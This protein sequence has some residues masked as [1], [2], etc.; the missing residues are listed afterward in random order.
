MLNN[1]LCTQL[2]K[3]SLRS[4]FFIISWLL[5]IDTGVSMTLNQWSLIC[6]YPCGTHRLTQR[7]FSVVWQTV[8]RSEQHLKGTGCYDCRSQS[9]HIYST[10]TLLATLW[11][12]G[13]LKKILIQIA[14]KMCFKPN[15]MHLRHYFI[16]HKEPKTVQ[17]FYKFSM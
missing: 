13:F 2:Y 1:L 16:L 14:C 4:A 12:G 5:P 15:L 6:D 17:N 9:S 8:Q 3:K 7:K 10:A 11:S